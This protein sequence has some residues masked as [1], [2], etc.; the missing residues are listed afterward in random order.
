MRLLEFLHHVTLHEAAKDQYMQMFAALTPLFQE[1]G[2][3]YEFKTELTNELNW[4]MRVLKKSDKIMWYLRYV[5]F[6]ILQR[7]STGTAVGEVEEM[8]KPHYAKFAKQVTTKSGRPVDN[9]VVDAKEVQGRQFKE[10]MQHFMSLEIPAFMNMTFGW[11][12][13]G[14]ILNIFTPIEKA[15]QKKAVATVPHDE[16]VTV[17][18]QFPDG[19]AWVD[20]EKNYCDAE[21]KAMGHCG[22]AADP[23]DED[24]VLSYRTIEDIEGMKMWK[25]RLTFILDKST[26][27]LG[28][29]K[30]RANQKPDQKYHNVIIK[31][32]QH[33]DIK[34]IGRG[35]WE[36]HNNFKMSDLPE[37]IADNL[38]E[39]KP[40]LA[41][42]EY[43]YKK[44]GMTQDLLNRI[45]VTFK[46]IDN[47]LEYEKKKKHF[48]FEKFKSIEQFIDGYYNDNNTITWV[49]KHT[50][51]GEFLEVDSYS[52]D[53][54]M[55]EEVLHA[56]EKKEPGTI[57][58]IGDYLVKRY[59]DD[60]EEWE[61]GQDHDFDTTDA[62]SIV[63]IVEILS[64][65]IDDELE[66]AHWSGS[67]WGT[68]DQMYKALMKHLELIESETKE[69]AA[70]F[71]LVFDDPENNVRAAIHETDL[72]SKYD[73]ILSE[74][75]ENGWEEY[76]GFL[77]DMDQPYYGWHEFSE[78]GAAERFLEEMSLEI[79]DP[80]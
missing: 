42:V 22:N 28:E 67:E 41:T 57:E 23:Y 70:A 34:G 24:T 3:E 32:L 66:R 36:V 1:S 73:E 33:P 51:G 60:I 20:L 59:P 37:D 31:L 6:N 16:E 47:P 69:S 56:A 61:E 53:S 75:E 21:A 45:L 72:V 58:K 38:I 13:P 50:L 7:M 25:P 39:E 54:S 26:G 35:R 74:V 4:A 49:A 71:S 77:K 30:G 12:R 11:E 80:S 40:A 55:K 17:M 8:F 52:V 14:D 64:D 62:S 15:W 44:M 79:P 27:L 5:K 78:E 29:M 76:F 19:S 68:G 2:L 65:D 9:W 63:D 10:Q 46:K 18:I 48:V 43:A